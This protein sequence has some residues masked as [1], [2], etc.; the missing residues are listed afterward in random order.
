MN[1]LRSKIN[2]F[3]TR[4]PL[5]LLGLLSVALVS[6]AQQATRAEALAMEQAQRTDEAEQRWNALSIKSPGDPEPLA[7]LGLLEARQEHYEAAIG[8]YRKALQL[9]PDFP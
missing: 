6:R 8:F 2:R 1:L 9:N 7:H 4:R 5:L 3:L